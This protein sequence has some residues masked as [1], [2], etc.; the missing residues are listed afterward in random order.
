MPAVG[1][2]DGFDDSDNL[3]MMQEFVAD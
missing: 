3:E 1:G 2:N